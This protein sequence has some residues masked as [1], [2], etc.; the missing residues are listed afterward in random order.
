MLKRS[1][2]P[3]RRLTRLTCFKGALAPKGAAAI[4]GVLAVGIGMVCVDIGLRPPA[5]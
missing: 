1:A 2:M 5:F 3:G 4:D